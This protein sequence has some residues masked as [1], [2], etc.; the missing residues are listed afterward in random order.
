MSTYLSLRWFKV[1]V[2]KYPVIDPF[3]SAS[4]TCIRV[5][6]S[7]GLALIKITTNLYVSYNMINLILFCAYLRSGIHTLSSRWLFKHTMTLD[8]MMNSFISTRNALIRK[9][10]TTSFIIIKVSTN[11][12]IPKY[13][14]S[15]YSFVQMC[16]QG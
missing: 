9:L 10:L 2:T 8:P 6:L 3:I 11:F 16:D 4:N 14:D 7:C 1:A 12:N 15:L 5:L 13:I